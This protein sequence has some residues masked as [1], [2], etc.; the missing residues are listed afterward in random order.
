MTVWYPTKN[1]VI[2]A[3]KA[4]VLVVK[5][6]GNDDPTKPRFVITAIAESGVILANLRDEFVSMG[7]AMEWLNALIRRDPE[8]KASGAFIETDTDIDFAPFDVSNADGEDL[9]LLQGTSEDFSEIGIAPATDGTYSTF[10]WCMTCQRW[11]DVP[12]SERVPG[13]ALVLEG[14]MSLSATV[15]AAY[16]HFATREHRDNERR[17]AHGGKPCDESC[18]HDLS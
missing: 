2:D 4:A 13:K 15:R 8:L 7:E 14:A 17:A 1:G 5:A 3:D 12:H 18:R 9:R 10:A 11:S 6:A 16:Q